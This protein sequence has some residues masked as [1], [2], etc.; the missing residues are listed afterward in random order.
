MLFFNGNLKIVATS[1]R[2]CS[3]N[4]FI[5]FNYLFFFNPNQLSWCQHLEFL[6]LQPPRGVC[7]LCRWIS[8]VRVCVRA[9]ACVCVCL[10]THLCSCVDKHW[11]RAWKGFSCSSVDSVGSKKEETGRKNYSEQ[12]Q[13]P[14]CPEVITPLPSLRLP[15]PSW[16]HALH[17]CVRVLNV[18]PCNWWQ[19]TSDFLLVQAVA[20]SEPCRQ[21]RV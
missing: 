2:P 16:G 6:W 10:C 17:T 5:I 14:P 9:R 3:L 8:S 7:R 15:L 19:Q 20:M 4:L 21:S 13:D 12:L 11:A 1:A 18:L